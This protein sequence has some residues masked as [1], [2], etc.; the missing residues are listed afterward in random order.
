MIHRIHVDTIV[1][2]LDDW[3]E[4]LVFL[5]HSHWISSVSTI[6]MPVRKLA[7]GTMVT[8]VWDV[9]DWNYGVSVDTIASWTLYSHHSEIPP[10]SSPFG[11]PGGGRDDSHPSE[12]R[13]MWNNQ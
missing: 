6:A 10:P 8:R 7:I 12:S 3:K 4:N 1:Q 11:H 9:E 2:K 5:F 13:R